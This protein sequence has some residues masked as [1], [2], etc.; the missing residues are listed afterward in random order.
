MR[1][2]GQARKLKR[3]IAGSLVEFQPLGSERKE[4]T[5][6]ID[7]GI[8]K[9]PYAGT[10]VQGCCYWNWGSGRNLVRGQFPGH[11]DLRY[12]GGHLFLKFY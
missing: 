8:W 1:V 3:P 7:K 10:W 12:S 11:P 6:E 5:D 9:D 4:V 2:R